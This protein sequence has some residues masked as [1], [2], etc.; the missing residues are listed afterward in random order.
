MASCETHQ[1]RPEVAAIRDHYDR[2]SVFYRAF[3]GDHIHHGYWEGRESSSAAQVRLVELLAARAR[4]ERGARVLDIGCGVGG[5]AL[6]LARKLGCS[7]TGLTISPVQAEMARE[8][9]ASEG[10]GDRVRFEVADAN[11]LDAPP[12]SFDTVWVMECS[13]HLVDKPQ[14]IADCARALRPQGVLALCAWLK[15][16]GPL[17]SEHEKLISEVCQGMLCPSLATMAEYVG[18]MRQSGFVDITSEDIT[19]RVAPTWEL[20]GAIAERPEVRTLLRV[21]DSA[22]RQFVAAFAAIRRAYKE[23]AMAYGIF[24]ARRP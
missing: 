9:A 3:W 11:R 12:G 16:D 6:W 23:R 10:L 21:S 4:I 22:S 19:A 13:E 18:W 14:L 17:S 15:A 24:T 7:V 2:L 5:P 8:R 1:G 20:C